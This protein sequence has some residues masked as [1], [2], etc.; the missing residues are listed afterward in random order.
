M[1]RKNI[2][3]TL[4]DGTRRDSKG[5]MVYL[6]EYYFPRIAFG[7]LDPHISYAFTWQGDHYAALPQYNQVVQARLQKWSEGMRGRDLL[8]QIRWQ[9][10]TMEMLDAW[11]RGKRA[12]LRYYIWRFCQVYQA[13]LRDVLGDVSLPADNR[14]CLDVICS[15][16]RYSAFCGRLQSDY[17]HLFHVGMRQY[18]LTNYHSDLFHRLR[19]DAYLLAWAKN[20]LADAE[21]TETTPEILLAFAEWSGLAIKHLIGGR[22]KI[23][24][25]DTTSSS[26]SCEVPAAPEPE[27]PEV[28]MAVEPDPD[29]EPDPEPPTEPA[30]PP[31]F[32]FFAGC[33]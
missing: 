31:V 2:V 13:T 1:K 10:R 12:P 27:L 9:V 17:L 32:D 24:K 23:G 30:A 6:K 8:E 26:S 16:P 20:L 19:R 18:W 22:Q 33:K 15:R 7:D 29:P 28:V 3:V 21:R 4:P 11:R 14:A 25:T 5:G